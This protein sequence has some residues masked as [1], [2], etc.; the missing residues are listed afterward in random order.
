MIV[1]E[2]GSL[3]SYATMKGV[4]RELGQRPGVETKLCNVV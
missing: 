3:L 2:V 4:R 1:N